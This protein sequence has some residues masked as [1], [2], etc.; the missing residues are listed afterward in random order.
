MQQMTKQEL[1]EYLHAL[2]GSHSLVNKW[3]ETRIPRF[4]AAPSSIWETEPQV[5]IDYVMNYSI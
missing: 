4:G 5:V 3:W 1:S 2:L